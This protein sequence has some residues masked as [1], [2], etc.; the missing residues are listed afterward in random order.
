[1]NYNNQKFEYSC[2]TAFTQAKTNEVFNALWHTLLLY[3]W[4]MKTNV[5]F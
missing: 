3:S 1:M 4:L 5:L 2:L